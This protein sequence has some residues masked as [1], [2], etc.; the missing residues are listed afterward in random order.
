[1]KN[2]K[3]SDEEMAKYLSEQGLMDEMQY[4]NIKQRSKA[5]DKWVGPAIVICIIISI[6]F[7]LSD[8]WQ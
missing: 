7:T 1:M 5:N 4:Q 6:L 8:I 2:G 3:M